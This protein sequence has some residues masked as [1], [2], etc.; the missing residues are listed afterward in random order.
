MLVS[1]LSCIKLQKNMHV[2]MYFFQFVWITFPLL[3]M[4]SP[5][6][7]PRLLIF[8]PPL[9]ILDPRHVGLPPPVHHLE[10]EVEQKEEDRDPLVSAEVETTISESSFGD[11]DKEQPTMEEK[12]EEGVSH[13]QP[14]EGVIGNGGS[15]ADREVEIPPNTNSKVH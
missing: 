1:A 12:R 11:G 5:I 8:A 9:P 2:S 10:P 15:Q 6:H 3:P 13:V 14:Y 4:R 7:A